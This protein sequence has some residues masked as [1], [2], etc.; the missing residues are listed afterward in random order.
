MFQTL[1][2]AN[3]TG[4]EWLAAMPAFLVL[5]F[6]ILLN[7]S[8]ATHAQL[9]KLGENVWDGYFQLRSDPVAPVC[10]LNADIDSQLAVL[11]A[12]S[13]VVAEEDEWDLFDED[14]EPI[15]ENVL[16]QSLAN[17][18]A[19]CE[20]KHQTYTNTVDRITP[21]VRAFR[22]V[23]LSVSDFGEFGLHAQRIM[24]AILVLICGM[25][26]L[27]RRHHIALRPMETVMDY[28][29]ASFAQMI[30]SG[31]LFYSVYSFKNVVFSAGIEVTV[32]HGFLHYLWIVGF[33]AVLL[34]SMYQFVVIPKDAKPGGSFMKAQLAVP[35]YA[36]MCIISGSYFIF[37][38]HAAG[39]GIYLNQMM[40]LSQLFLNVGLYVWIGMLVKRT[41]LAQA[42]FN[43]FRPWNMP[44]ECWRLS[45]LLLPL[46]P[47]LIQAR[48]VFL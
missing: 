31:I 22:A 20:S 1:R 14:P 24:L 26:A 46:C 17:A 16:R 13:A 41:K 18:H 37:N 45:L 40:E 4:F 44:P 33:G 28:R 21:A 6:V 12:E 11:I 8:H 23:E 38:G 39:I 48:R 32:E 29:V 10:D 9:L 2:L 36:T 47:P 43:I 19:V 5:I 42:V 30:A 27:F 3:R 15:D 35:L 25:T 34:L 7:T